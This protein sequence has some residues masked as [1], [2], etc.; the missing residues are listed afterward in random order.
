MAVTGYCVLTLISGA[1][2]TL[3]FTVMMKCSK[4]TPVS[5]QATHYTTLATAEVFGK[6]MFT[7]LAGYLADA[8]GYLPVFLL[9]VFLASFSIVLFRFCPDIGAQSI[10]PILPQPDFVYSRLEFATEEEEEVEMSDVT[11]AD[12]MSD[13]QWLRKRTHKTTAATY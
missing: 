4:N 6:L 2:T 7:S 13:K 3:T 9:C 8:M 1:L 10:N 5:A 11:A 12:D